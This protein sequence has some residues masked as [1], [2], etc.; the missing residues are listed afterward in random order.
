M[1]SNIENLIYVTL[2]QKTFLK[3]V[4]SAAGM[5]KCSSDPSTVET[6]YMLFYA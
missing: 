5:L 2:G 1:P 6:F 4:I 3:N